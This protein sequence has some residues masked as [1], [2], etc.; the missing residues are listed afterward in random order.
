MKTISPTADWTAPYRDPAGREAIVAA[1]GE[2]FDL[3]LGRRTYDIWTGF[4]P[5]APNSP[6]AD[7]PKRERRNTSRPTGRTVLHGGR[8]RASDRTSS[9]AFAASRRRTD[10]T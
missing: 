1:H 8:P 4:W 3:L 10:R 2:S 5:N 6:M 7:A 9:R